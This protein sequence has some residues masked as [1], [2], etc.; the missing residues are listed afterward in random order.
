[1]SQTVFQKYWFAVFKVKVT[2]KYSCRQRWLYNMSSELLI[3]LQLKWI[4]LMA[5]NHELDFL[6]KRLDFSV[7]VKVTEKVQNSSDCSYEW[8]LLSCWTL[9]NQSWYGDA[10]S[11][12][13]VPCKK[14]YLLSSTSGSQWGL[15][16][17]DMTVST[18]TAERLIFLQPIQLDSTSS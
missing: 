9:C 12:V 4:G 16:W 2:V 7:V 11:W 10:T 1:M 17:S 8:Y 6:V 3:L 5:S 13:K 15:I 18:I 14:I